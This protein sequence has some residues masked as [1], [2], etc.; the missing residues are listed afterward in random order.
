[1]LDCHDAA[2]K[3]AI[4]TLWTGIAH[5]YHSVDAWPEDEKIAAGGM[6]AALGV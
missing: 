3:S 2:S 1:L 4:D 6:P 5:F